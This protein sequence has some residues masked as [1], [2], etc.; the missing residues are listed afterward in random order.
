MMVLYTLLWP[1]A[2]VLRYY[3]RMQTLTKQDVLL[4]WAL[5]EALSP[6]WRDYYGK[7]LSPP[8]QAALKKGSMAALSY[9]DREELVAHLR[10]RRPEYINEYIEPATRFSFINL[11]PDALEKICIS[12]TISWRDK[13]FT[14]A[15]FLTGSYDPNTWHDPRNAAQRM[16]QSP[17]KVGYA[18]Y[19]IFAYDRKVRC[20][21]L[22]EGY[23]RCICKIY[24]HRAGERVDGTLAILCSM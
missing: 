2:T 24:K 14:L 7:Q 13:P 18:G 21:I 9:A 6:R 16:Q 1:A 12:P 20:D 8:L 23:T 4:S 22:I 3:R 5:S 19:P 15:Q 17:E 10:E 11:P